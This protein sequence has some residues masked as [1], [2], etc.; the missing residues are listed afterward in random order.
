MNKCYLYFPGN[1]EMNGRYCI[2]LSWWF[3]MKILK[4][5]CV[6]LKEASVGSLECTGNCQIKGNTNIECLTRVLGHHRHWLRVYK[7]LELY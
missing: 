4:G 5:F 6:T 2:S 7:C 3:K 1:I